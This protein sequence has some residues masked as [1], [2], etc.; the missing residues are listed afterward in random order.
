MK[1][2]VVIVEDPHVDVE[3]DV[4]TD[5]DAA[6]RAARDVVQQYVDDGDVCT[7]E[8]CEDHGERSEE[9]NESM[10]ADGWVFHHNMNEADSVRVVERELKA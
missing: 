4:Y 8:D 9:L 2:Y 6:I 10:V 5:Q 7:S 3:V 1:V